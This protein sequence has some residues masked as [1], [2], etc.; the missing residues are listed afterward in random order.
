MVDLPRHELA[1]VR[2]GAEC[3]P[4]HVPQVCDGRRHHD[5][6]DHDGERQDLP[7]AEA[8]PHAA[9]E[10]Y[11]WSLLCSVL[12]LMPRISA[13]RA[14]LPPV[15]LRVRKISSRSASSTVV[16]TGSTR[17]P[18]VADATGSVGVPSGGRCSARTRPPEHTLTARS[19]T[20]RSSRTLPG[21]RCRRSTSSALSS[22]PRTPRP[23][24]SLNSSTNACARSGRSSTRS[25]S[26]G[27]EM[28]K[29]LSR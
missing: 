19:I 8:Q 18:S 10:L 2:G 15:C 22:T 26:G 7:R 3:Q 13:A 20:L 27:S 5:Q 14:L 4:S 12:R 6:Q 9:Q 17:S 25:R 23:C 1:L 16:P 11:L 29:T 24:R 21:H 28:A